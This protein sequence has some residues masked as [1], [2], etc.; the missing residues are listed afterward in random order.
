[1][2]SI[3]TGRLSSTPEFVACP[4]SVQFYSDDAAFLDRTTD[5]LG[6]AFLAG[7]PV[8]VIA[9]EQHR[10][11]LQKRL[12]AQGLDIAAARQQGCYVALDASETLAKFMT[13]N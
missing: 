5:F 9:T 4:H 11:G 6:Q 1:M 7:S 2:T 13:E 3:A 8:I 10:E 12:E